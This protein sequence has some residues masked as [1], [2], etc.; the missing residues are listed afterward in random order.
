[1]SEPFDI[2]VV[3]SGAG[4]A[5]VAHAAVRAGR[6]VLMLEQGGQLPR[7]RSTLDVRQ[8]FREGRFS[9]REMWVDG[10]NKQFIP[11]EY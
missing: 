6:R 11:R 9:N 5:A 3:G 10:Y 1:M 7:D 4:G 2:V 8:V